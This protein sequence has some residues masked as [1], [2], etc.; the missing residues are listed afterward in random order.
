M[1]FCAW[2]EEKTLGQFNRPHK[3]VWYPIAY[4]I[5]DLMR[6]VLDVVSMAPPCTLGG[7]LITKIPP[8]CEVKPHADGGWHAEHYCMKHAV[9]LAGNK[10]QSFQFEDASL[11]PESG[12]VFEFDNSRVHW[13]TN[14]S[15][16]DRITMIICMRPIFMDGDS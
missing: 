7:V 15:Q 16:E 3:S 4:E 6:I 10:G 14:D 8:G 9:Q 12:E 11:S 13:V 1:R 2:D 5:P